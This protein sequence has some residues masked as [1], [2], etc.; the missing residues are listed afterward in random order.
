MGSGR[1]GLEEFFLGGVA[2]RHAFEGFDFV[3][4]LSDVFELTVD[5]GVAD[6]GDGVDVLEFS[7]DKRADS[8]GWNFTDILGVK[9][10]D[11]I[12]GGLFDGFDTDGAFFAGFGDAIEEFFTSKVFADAVAFDDAEVAPL[13]V[14]VGGEAFSA[15]VAFAA[16]SDGGAVF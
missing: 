9:F 15:V 4:K 10:I 7:H 8:L 12:F 14:F 5:G 2:V 1:G 16:S 11:D 6:V 13:E 3:D